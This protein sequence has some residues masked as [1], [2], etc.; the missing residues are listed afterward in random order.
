ME[1]NKQPVL[2]AP[3]AESAL[4]TIVLFDG[5]CGLCNQFVDLLLRHDKKEHLLFAPLQ[6]ETARGLA[7][8]ID[9]TGLQTVVFYKHG[10]L[11]IKSDAVIEIF[12]SMGGL[13]RVFRLGRLIPKNVRDHIY[14]WVARNRIKW[15]GQ[16]LSCRMPADKEKGRL[17]P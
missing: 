17:L 5:V 15:F 2:A 11:F 14:D 8:N 12:S 16:K 9:L 1:S 7:L 6:G 4:A 3:G 13:W 10:Q